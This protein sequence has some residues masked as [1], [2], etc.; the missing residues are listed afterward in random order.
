[1]QRIWFRRN[2]REQYAQT[3]SSFPAKPP[4]PRLS[5]GPARSGERS[6]KSAAEVDSIKM[7]NTLPERSSGS[8]TS[9][10]YL[11]WCMILS[12][13]PATFRDYA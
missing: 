2:L 13:R 3:A 12:E 9:A 8:I 4:S 5:P 7:E 10:L 11:V 6:G 1:M